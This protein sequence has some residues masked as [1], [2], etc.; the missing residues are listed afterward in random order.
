[1]TARLIVALLTPLDTSLRCQVDL[2]A[3]HCHRLLNKG[4]D[5]LAL[6]GTT[7]Y[8][9]SFST[10]ER[11]EALEGL[12]AAGVPADRL[13]VGTSAASLADTIQLTRHAANTGCTGSFVMPP[14]FFH[15][16]SDEGVEDMYVRL[17]D[18]AASE[19]LRLYLYNLP[20]FHGAPIAIDLLGKL[21]ARYPACIA[22]IKDSSGD[23][24]YLEAL[25][26]TYPNLEVYTGI[27]PLLPQA[28]EA[29]GAGAITGLSNLVPGLLR[30]LCQTADTPTRT[31]ALVE[32]QHLV[33]ALP[34]TA[35]IETLAGL[36][37]T[38]SGEPSWQNMPPPL[39]PIPRSQLIAVAR[40]YEEHNEWGLQAAS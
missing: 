19:S 30:R 15:G 12:I 38:L 25:L 24:H 5:G 26:R 11:I 35:I 27:E 18:A 33:D 39:R 4:V 3:R 34:R 16:T 36:M 40:S 32:T 6:F 31:A 21:S 28:L 1:M 37:A 8:G 22:G 10:S 20:Q 9:P 2:L 14:F 29:G 7:G 23:W 13:L 17:L